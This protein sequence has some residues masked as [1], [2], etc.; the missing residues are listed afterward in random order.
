MS[1]GLSRQPSRVKVTVLSFKH[2][3]WITAFVNIS[4]NKWAVLSLFLH[5]RLICNP[6]IPVYT[7]WECLCEWRF[8]DF[9]TASKQWQWPGPCITLVSHI[10]SSSCG[11]R[12]KRFYD[13]FSHGRSFCRSLQISCCPIERVKLLIQNQERDSALGVFFVELSKWVFHGRGPHKFM[14]VSHQRG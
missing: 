9:F 8:A 13:W 2:R 1:C 14:S 5:C 10:C 12:C 11:E 4:E 7:V 6:E 3:G